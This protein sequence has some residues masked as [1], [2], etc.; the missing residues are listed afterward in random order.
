MWYVSLKFF[1][2]PPWNWPEDAPVQTSYNYNYD[3]Q[4][5]INIKYFVGTCMRQIDVWMKWMNIKYIA[6]LN[7]SKLY[8]ITCLTDPNDSGDKY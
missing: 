8:A 1:A 4:N 3:T 2:H 5:Y 6:C 7:V